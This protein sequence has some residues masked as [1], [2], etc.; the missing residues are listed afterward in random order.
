MSTRTLRWGILGT[1]NIAR[2]NWRALRLAGNATLTAVASRVPG[3]ARRFIREC[4]AEVPFPSEPVAFDDYAALLASPEVDAVYVPLPTGQRQEWLRRAAAAGKHIVG[5][6]PCATSAAELAE[7]LH[8][9]RSRGLQ[10]MDGVMFHHSARTARMLEVLRDG[11]T[12]GTLRRIATQ[13]S[14]LAPPD[15]AETNIR[16]HSGLEPQGCVGDLGWY[17]LRLILLALDGRVPDRVV[18][19]QFAS[20]RAPGARASV[21]AEVAGDLLYP[22]G[23]SASFYCSFRTLNQQWAH[24]SG[25]AGQIFIP[26]FVLPFASDTLA[27]D[28]LQPEFTVAGCESRMEPR[29][30]RIVV[31]EHSHG[32]AESPEANLF[33]H[34]SDRV[35]GGQLE[36]AWPDIA[37]RNQ[38]VLDAVMQSLAAGGEATAIPP[39]PASPGPLG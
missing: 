9:C 19:R 6:K 39:L 8:A 35:L 25:T 33:R 27:F 5:E 23:V 21:P 13:F 32:A 28:V 18:A 12:V 36:P 10:F 29:A 37:L 4:Q 17:C 11:T 16:A 3:Q 26:D 24:L 22:D 7:I 2:K 20:M 14:F 30:R 15:F 31:A 38:Q 1:A 34:F